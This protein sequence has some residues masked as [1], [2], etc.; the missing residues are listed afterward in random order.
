[1]HKTPNQKLL[2]QM[3]NLDMLA[4]SYNNKMETRRLNH[5]AKL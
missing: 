4:A 5:K 1:M 3:N 2:P